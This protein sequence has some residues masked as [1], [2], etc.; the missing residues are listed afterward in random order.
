MFEGEST[1]HIVNTI[2]L[3][4][5]DL[6]VSLKRYTKSKLRTVEKEIMRR[7]SR[8]VEND[9]KVRVVGAETVAQQPWTCGTEAHHG[10]DPGAVYGTVREK[11]FFFLKDSM[12]FFF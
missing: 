1:L 11:I 10:A 6:S 5:E 7:K 3:F 9:N 12:A 2:V 8:K 4:Q